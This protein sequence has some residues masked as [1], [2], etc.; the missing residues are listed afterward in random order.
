VQI[1][2]QLAL[3]LQEAAE[4][5]HDCLQLTLREKQGG[6]EGE[7]DSEAETQEAE[8]KRRKGMAREG[9]RELREKG[10][11][12]GSPALQ[13]KS[14]KEC[15]SMKLFWIGVPVRMIRTSAGTLTSA[16]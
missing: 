11:R 3:T 15:A 8:S 5:I 6:E 14:N 10:V 13:A 12:N 1:R 7:G 4:R 9:G 16:W 2:I